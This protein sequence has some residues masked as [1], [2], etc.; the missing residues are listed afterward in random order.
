MKER[1]YGRWMEEKMAE[2][3]GIV[4]DYEQMRNIK[5]ASVL[6]FGKLIAPSARQS[7]YLPGL[8]KSRPSIKRP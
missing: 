2:V 3:R 1:N 6:E 4:R 8:G 7:E 5:R